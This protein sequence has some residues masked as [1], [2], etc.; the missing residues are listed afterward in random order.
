MYPL[1]TF[2]SWYHPVVSGYNIG[3]R[4]PTPSAKNRTLPSLSMSLCRLSTATSVFPL[5]PPHL[6]CLL[7]SASLPFFL[8][9]G[10]FKAKFS[11]PFNLLFPRKIILQKDNSI[12]LLHPSKLIRGSN[13]AHTCHTDSSIRSRQIG[14]GTRVNFTGGF[15][16]LRR[17]YPNRSLVKSLNLKR[18]F[19]FLNSF[20]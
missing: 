5:P 16:F 9:L 3:T 17:N 6:L 8:L 1:Q 19:S 18:K 12:P 2:S 7:E 15:F 11:I 20:V 4:M 13:P 14:L 10:Y